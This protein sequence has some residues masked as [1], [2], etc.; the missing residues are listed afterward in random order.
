MKMFLTKT[1]IST[2][3][4]L[5]C[6]VL[7]A[8]ALNAEHNWQALDGFTP[9]PSKMTR[10][11]EDYVVM[12]YVNREQSLMAAVF[13][14]ASCDI[15]GCELERRAGYAIT[16]AEGSDVKLYIDPRDRAL[17]AL[18]HQFSLTRIDRN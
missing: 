12:P 3:V 18:V 6:T 4:L 14:A 13:F 10:F 15:A 5:S 1:I 8:S 16:N 2:L 9:L 7:P 17:I 11:G